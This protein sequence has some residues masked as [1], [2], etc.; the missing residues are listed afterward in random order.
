MPQA[1]GCQTVYRSVLSLACLH[2]VRAGDIRAAA[3]R[4]HQPFLDSLE[5]PTLAHVATAKRKDGGGS[6]D[7]RASRNWLEIG[8]FLEVGER[9]R[10]SNRS[11]QCL[12]LRKILLERRRGLLAHCE[13]GAVQAGDRAWKAR[14]DS[15]GRRHLG[16]LN[17][18]MLSRQGKHS[19]VAAAVCGYLTA[20]CAGHEP[21]HPHTSPAGM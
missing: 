18:W 6:N 19:K 7:P 14:D 21:L 3:N 17:Q 15:V 11:S 9:G 13:R 4:L 16:K 2:F 12:S 20:L 8:H 1:R 5:P 10:R